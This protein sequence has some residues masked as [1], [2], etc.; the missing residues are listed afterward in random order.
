[1]AASC[2]APSAARAEP[3][4]HL[5]YVAIGDSV[6]AAPGVPDPA[7]PLG[8][9]KSSN[10]YP[11][12]LARRISPTSFTDVTCSGA[13]T[14]DITSRSQHT[15]AG[16]VPPQIDAVSARTD[17]ITITIG[18]NDAGLASEAAPCRAASPDAR[19][20][21]DRFLSGDVD[22]VSAIITAKVAVWAAMIDA[23]RA[24]APRARIIL[25][26][27]GTFFPRGGCFPEQP[28]LPSDADYFQSK[29]DE[30][31]DRQRQLAAEKGIDYF[32]TRPLST[33]HDMCAAPSDRYVEGFAARPPA[34]PLHPNALGTAAVGN[35]L[36]DYIG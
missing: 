33:G 6:A 31:D 16:V 10:N 28:V 25:V 29:A 8:C 4:H 36:A 15:P 26:G 9:G 34:E 13:T 7:Q 20:C 3:H 35:A 14:E 21:A 27:Y 5:N 11:S 19:P 22:R 2:A 30:L 18:G 12:M 1:M 17:L 32:D 23:L 24:R